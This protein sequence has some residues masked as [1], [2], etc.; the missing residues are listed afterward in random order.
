MELCYFLVRFPSMRWRPRK[1][2]VLRYRPARWGQAG[3]QLRSRAE[4]GAPARDIGTSI[5]KSGDAQG[6]G[7]SGRRVAS[8]ASKERF[9]LESSAIRNSLRELELPSE[10]K[11]LLTQVGN[12]YE[13]SPASL[14]GGTL[15]V[16]G[17]AIG[18]G[19]VLETPFWPSP[20]N[21]SLACAICGDR[22][23][24][25]EGAFQALTQALRL[26]PLSGSARGKSVEGCR[27]HL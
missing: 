8:P 7:E 24:P 6:N 16:S 25:I 18:N 17:V 10:F 14:L 1:P 22:T 15:S 21:A 26:E 4:A 23:E 20:V 12:H 13:L 19:V 2:T 27:R 3:Q 9:G 5:P 11:R